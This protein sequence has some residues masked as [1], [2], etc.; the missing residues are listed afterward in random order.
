MGK[1]KPCPFCGGKVSVTY[2]SWNKT[3]NIWHDDNQCALIE[4]MQIDG[5]KANSLK[6]ASDLWNRRAKT[7]D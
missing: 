2:S 3:F 7:W 4:P 6:E 5:A 1:L